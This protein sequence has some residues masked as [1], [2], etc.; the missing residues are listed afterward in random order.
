M[1]SGLCHVCI[2]DRDRSLFIAQRAR[3]TSVAAL[4][5]APSWRDRLAWVALSAIPAGLVIAVTSYLT[6][7]IAAAPFLWVLPLA[8]YLLTFVAVFRDRPW[9]APESV[10]KVVPFLVAPLAIGLLGR[11]HVFWLAMVAINLV[12]FV[13]LAL[14]CHGRLYCRR[15]APA[16]LTEFYLLVSLGG[17]LGG[18]FAA[19]MAPQIFSRVYEYPILIAAALLVLP[20]M[21]SGGVRGLLKEAGL[22]LLIAALAVAIQIEFDLRLPATAELPFQIALVALAAIMLLQRARPARFFAWWCSAS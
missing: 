18:I 16:C 8:L 14:L 10:A 6:T 5:A 22:I 2:P 7:N 17:V 19:L 3:I 15:P 11:D 1:G 20:G 4:E 13:L 21:W 12:A 9:V